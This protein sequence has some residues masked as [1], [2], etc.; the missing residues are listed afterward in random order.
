MTF[1][2]LLTAVLTAIILYS[3]APLV[4]TEE[5]SGGQCC[6]PS[7]SCP[8]GYECH[9]RPGDVCSASDEGHCVPI[10]D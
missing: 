8:T 1:K 10:G 4:V 7:T 6:G 3:A 5:P 9:L 2:T